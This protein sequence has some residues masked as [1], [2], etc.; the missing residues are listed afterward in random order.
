MGWASDCE[1]LRNFVISREG[2][3]IYT[4]SE[5]REEVENGYSDCSSLMWKAY[6]KIGV[7]I[8]TYTGEQIENSS[9]LDVKTEF[10]RGIPDESYMID[11]DLLFFSSPSSDYPQNVSHVEMYMGKGEISGHGFGTGPT[12]KI[13]KEYCSRRYIAGKPI[14]CVRRAKKIWYPYYVENCYT[15]ILNRG[16]TDE[17][18]S[19]WVSELNNGSSFTSVREGFIYSSENKNRIS[20]YYEKY[21]SRTPSE[22][23]ILFW[24]DW[25]FNTMSYD[26]ETMIKN[27]PEALRKA[28]SNA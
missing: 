3:N 14:I 11:G 27:S 15:D 13:L 1:T 26:V 7:Y 17:E 24:C 21:L 6:E 10:V 12:R 18:V 22:E 23:E 19:F 20:N 8:G 9:L 25:E 2:K 28:D 16:A 5:R 4:Q